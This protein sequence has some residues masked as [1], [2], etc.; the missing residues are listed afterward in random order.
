[1]SSVP[2]QTNE[3]NKPR[4]IPLGSI[5]PTC[6][7]PGAFGYHSGMSGPPARCDLGPQFNTVAEDGCTKMA[8]GTEA[9][10]P[11]ASLQAKAPEHRQ[12]LTS[13]TLTYAQAAQGTPIMPQTAPHGL[14]KPQA[15]SLASTESLIGRH[16]EEYALSPSGPSQPHLPAYP[17]P[18][19]SIRDI[20]TLQEDLFAKFSTLIE[21]GLAN[22]ATQITNSI[23]SVLTSLGSRIEAME[24]KIE[25]T[26]SRTNQNTAHLQTLQEQLDTALSRIYDLENRS[27]RYHFR[28]RGLPESFTDI[29][30]TVQ[31][32]IS[33]LIPDI[34]SHHLELDRAH[35]A[36]GPPRKDGTPRDIIVKPYFFAVKEEVMRQSC[37]KPKLQH[38]GHQMQ[39][40]ADLSPSTIPRKRS[41]KPLLTVLAQRDVKYCW[42][43]PFA[44]KFTMQ[45]KTHSFSNL[46]G[47]EKLFL[48]LKLI[49]QEAPMDFSTSSSGSSKR[50]PPASPVS[51]LW[52]K[53]PSKK[54]KDGRP[55]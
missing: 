41:L 7:G 21:R 37:L 39:I 18:G 46:P 13:A 24:D 38:Q 8:A 33:E 32:I 12:V 54:C 40:F 42:T 27:R 30:L 14:H 47:G 26:V 34:P 17:S 51:P 25:S 44:V 49:S 9:K 50:P 4:Y 19:F 6:M 43:F 48:S 10:Q 52:N 31:D 23:K 55:P 45:G 15:S 16:M 36:L 5:P 1:M 11:H 2:P 29:P 35:R 22:T 3:L 20:T 28:I 53:G